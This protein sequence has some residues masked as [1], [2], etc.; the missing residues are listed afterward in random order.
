MHQIVASKREEIA[1]LC[2][3]HGVKALEVFG[4]AAR[5]SDFREEDSDI[6]FLVTYREARKP[7]ALGQFFGLRDELSDLL[8]RPV[9]LIEPGAVVNP[10]VRAEVERNREVVFAG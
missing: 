4:S 1:A 9:D 6:D 8:G 10:Y 5:V 2:R 3:R 7:D